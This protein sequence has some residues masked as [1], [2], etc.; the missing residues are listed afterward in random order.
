MQEGRDSS[1][2]LLFLVVKTKGM[3]NLC[4]PKLQSIPQKTAICTITAVILIFIDYNR[5]TNKSGK[6]KEGVDRV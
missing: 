5:E 3:E 4:K 6:H 2:S 1:E